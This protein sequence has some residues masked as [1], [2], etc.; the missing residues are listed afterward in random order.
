VLPLVVVAVTKAPT[1]RLNL[2]APGPTLGVRRVRGPL[3]EFAQLLAVPVDDPVP[4]LAVVPAA[5]FFDQPGL[6]GAANQATS[7]R[8][9]VPLGGLLVVMLAAQPAAPLAGADLAPLDLTSPHHRA[10]QLLE[11]PP[12]AVDHPGLEPVGVLAAKHPPVQRPVDR[13][14]LD[15]A[16]TFRVDR[17]I[18]APQI[19]RPPVEGQPP[20]APLAPVGRAEPPGVDLGRAGI[21]RTIH[22]GT[23]AVINRRP[24]ASRRWKRPAGIT[25][26]SPIANVS[27]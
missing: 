20:A 14:A 6:V 8:Y 12:V 22:L 19:G 1:D 24:S 18:G 5:E 10:G 25:S 26:R 15:P 17:Y 9:R 23:S 21:E 27:W 13:T 4:V 16:P 3:E 11:R 2:T 7:P